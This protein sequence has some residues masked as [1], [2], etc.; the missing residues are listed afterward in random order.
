MR[1]VILL[2]LLI[3]C[4]PV[5]GQDR[6]LVFERN[7]TIWVSRWD[8]TQARKLYTGSTPT[9]SPDGKRFVFEIDRGGRCMAI[10]PVEGGKFQLIP[11][12]KL[13]LRPSWSPDGSQILFFNPVED[14][15]GAVIKPDGS[16][17]AVVAAETDGGC[18]SDD[19]QSL[20]VHDFSTLRQLKLDGLELRNWD[21][22]RLLGGF[23]PDS[24][25]RLSMLNGKL[26]LDA[27]KDTPPIGESA[28]WLVDLKAG[29]A[30]RLVDGHGPCWEDPQTF[31]YSD[32]KDNVYRYRLGSKKPALVIKNGTWPS[33]R[34]ASD[35]TW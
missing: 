26:L 7:G 11:G 5:L 18:W 1:T 15:G 35:G 6:P 10:A 8:G 13:A 32:N 28:I 29:T 9:L 22:T 27:R 33:P 21:L 34:R 24:S 4:A 14:R 12:P 16:G 3:C 31:L 19:G 2:L 17:Y 23:L 25:T 20:Y 30:K